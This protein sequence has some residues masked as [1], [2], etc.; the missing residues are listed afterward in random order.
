M[1]WLDTLQAEAGEIGAVNCVLRQEDRLIG[2]NTDIQGI[3]HS[4]DLMGQKFGY[5]VIL[6]TGGAS[7]AVRYVLE[8]RG[9]QLLQVGRDPVRSD[10]LFND[11]GLADILEA[12]LLVNCTP[13]GTFPE[14]DGFPPVPYDAIH[15]GQ[16]LFDL[17][18]NPEQT[19]FLKYGGAR[20]ARTLNGLP[21]LIAQAEASW[22]I[23]NSN[24][25]SR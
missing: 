23:W 5:A 3:E 17:V 8:K 12:D 2:Y 6:G 7:K 18:Y 4:L 20:G 1:G 24:E 14:V 21:M 19:K 25:S 9:I 15:E 16:W 11:L 22:N 10:V 13:L